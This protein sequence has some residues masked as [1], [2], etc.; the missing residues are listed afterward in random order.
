MRK[1]RIGCVNMYVQNRFRKSTFF[2]CYN[3][4]NS[5][6]MFRAFLFFALL[7]VPR[8]AFAVETEVGNVQT[9][10]DLVSQIWAWGTQI[11]FGVS[12][13]MII[14]GGILYMAARG[15]EE[16]ID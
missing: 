12:V 1:L 6:S 7:L 14:I 16:K 9:F 4:K 10:G 11:I 15:E 5:P 2:F 3:L 8:M 13:I